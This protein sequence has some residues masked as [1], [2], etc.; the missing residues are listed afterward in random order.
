MITIINPNKNNTRPNN[1]LT[2]YQQK[3]YSKN[4]NKNI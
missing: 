2:N 3:A 4:K 1:L